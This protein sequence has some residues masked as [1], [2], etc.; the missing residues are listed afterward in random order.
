MNIK[1]QRQIKAYLVEEFGKDQGDTL[2]DKQE[3]VLFT[4][5]ENIKNKTKNHL[6]QRWKWYR[7]FIRSTAVYF[8]KLCGQPT[9]RGVY[10]NMEKISMMLRLRSAFVIQLV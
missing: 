8:L 2:Y 9:Y 4:L 6:P 3:K 1:Q 5:I 10:K 7:D